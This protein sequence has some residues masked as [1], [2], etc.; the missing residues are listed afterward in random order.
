MAATN[1]VLIGG[2]LNTG[3]SATVAYTSPANGK[4]TRI[5]SLT[6]FNVNVATQSYKVYIVSSA[7]AAS[8]S[9][10]IVSQALTPDESET[11]IEI[12]NQFVPAGGTIQIEGSAASAIAFRASGIEFT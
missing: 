7:A 5:T 10:T 8:P 6:A 11:P 2:V 12:I 9:D 3:T 4:G 1:A